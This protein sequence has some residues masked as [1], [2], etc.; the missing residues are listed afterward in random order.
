MVTLA[1]RDESGLVVVNNLASGLAPGSGKVNG[2]RKNC[3][4]KNRKK[5]TPQ[6]GAFY[7]C[8]HN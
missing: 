5:R 7:R 1:Y 2:L 4:R 6:Y 8:E 3:S